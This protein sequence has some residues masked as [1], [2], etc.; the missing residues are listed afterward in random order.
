VP[1]RALA[2]ARVASLPGPCAPL[3]GP[4]DVDGLP[5]PWMAA[6]GQGAPRA[7]SVGP[8]APAAR[9]LCKLQLASADAARG[10]S[11]V[12]PAVADAAPRVLASLQAA[13][14]EPNQ[15]PRGKTQGDTKLNQINTPEGTGGKGPP[16]PVSNQRIQV[17]ISMD[18]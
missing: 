3:P 5:M 14:H 1:L 9:C 13:A 6:A 16:F 7:W 10:P 18:C 15:N 12:P 4:R 11:S 17:Q 8:R 2:A